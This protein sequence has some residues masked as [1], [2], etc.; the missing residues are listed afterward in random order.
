L[1]SDHSCYYTRIVQTAL[2]RKYK[3]GQDCTKEAAKATCKATPEIIATTNPQ[4][5]NLMVEENSFKG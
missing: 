3:D 2:S 4:G 1:C 5:K